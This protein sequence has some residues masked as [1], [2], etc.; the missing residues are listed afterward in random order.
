MQNAL[1]NVPTSDVNSFIENMANLERQ[2]GKQTASPLLIRLDG[3]NGKFTKRHFDQNK[4][5]MVTEPFQGGTPWTGTV[6]IAKY[7]AQWKYNTSGNGMNFR[8]REFTNFSMSEIELLKI[9]YNSKADDKIVETKTFDNYPAF[10]KEYETVDKASKKVSYPF[11]LW[12]S[13]YVYR[14]DLDTVVNYRFKGDTRSNYFDYGKGYRTDNAIKAMVQVKTEF[15]T[16]EKQMPARDGKEAKKYYCGTFTTLGVNEEFEM[17]R[18]M[19]ITRELSNWMS[20]FSKTEE[21]PDETTVP[22]ALVQS[23]V[24]E[25]G[26]NPSFERGAEPEIRLED[27]PF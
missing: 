14:H 23:D 21:L 6:I 11:D 3:D 8:T 16:E 22:P 5:E 19:E 2:G 9:D 20:S 13:L 1:S 25:T 10:K 27:I 12:V 7:Y 18:I 15:G 24:D 17:K 26:Y 4:R